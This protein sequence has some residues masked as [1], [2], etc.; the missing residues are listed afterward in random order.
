MCKFK[1]AV[2]IIF[3]T[4]FSLSLSGCYDYKEPGDLAYVVA[5]GV[6]KSDN[7]GTYNYTIQYARPTE[8]TGG[9][10]SEGGSGKD[11]MSILNV[12][13]PSV[14]A[15]VNLANHVV[16]K[17]FTLAHTK[18]IVISD[19]VAKESI[20]PIM[21]SI[22]R[23]SDIRPSVYMCVSNGEAREYLKSV[24][25]VVEIHPVKYYR[26]IFENKYS[27]YI[28]KTDVNDVYQ[29]LK[30]G[31]E[32]S[33]VPY[34]GVGK[35]EDEAKNSAEGADGSQDSSGGGSQKSSGGGEDS[36]KEGGG[37]SEE[38]GKGQSQGGNGE[39]EQSQSKEQKNI[40]TNKSGF[41]YDMKEYIAGNLDIEKTNKSEVIGSAVFN[42]DRMVTTLS[43]IESELYNIIKGDFQN[44]YSVIYSQKSPDH[45]ITIKIEQQKR[46]KIKVDAKG[47]KPKIDVE[48]FLEADFVSVPYDYFAESEIDRFEK[49]TT[50]YIKEAI[51][52][53]LNSTSRQY[54]TD[55][56]GFARYAKINFLTY[57]E[58]NNYKW[59]D[60]YQNAQ[61]LCNVNFSIRR[62]GLII[63]TDETQ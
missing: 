9:S 14:Y 18:I 53:F 60:K 50:K 2:L 59:N 24:K 17:S 21:D 57:D 54:K 39:G 52:K 62:T 49:E 44:G 45:P 4:M 25:P 42:G 22:G 31:D 35:G 55:V 19:T 40:P 36:Q 43:N 32:Q 30:S 10:S 47:I 8:I 33:I 16:S 63:R 15:A 11:T 27:S 61:F 20:T 1:K 6:D 28:P 46:P 34:V 51:E 48:V 37:S 7:E 12:E 38:G 29:N 56:C 23:S 41:E 26:L 13:A 58:F 3:A 5:I